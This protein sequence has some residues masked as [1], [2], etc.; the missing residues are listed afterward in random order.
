MAFKLKPI[1]DKARRQL[2]TLYL[3][4]KR[5]DVSG[6]VNACDA[7]R[8]GELIFAYIMD[9]LQVR[10]PVERLWISSMTREAIRNGLASLVPGAEMKNLEDASRSRSEADW[11]VGLN[12]TRAATIRARGHIPGVV[13]LG[14]VQTPTLAMIVKRDL[15]IA[16]FESQRFFVLKASFDLGYRGTWIDA[17]GSAR[18]AGLDAA[19]ALAEKVRGQ[20]GA[21]ANVERREKRERAPLLYD[22]TTLQRE[23]NRYYGLSAK[24]TLALAQSLYEKHKAIT[25]PRTDSRFLSSDMKPLLKKTA[26]TLLWHAPYREAVNYVCAL[27]TLPDRIIDD[28]KVSDHHAIIPTIAEHN[29]SAWSDHER[30]IFDL[31]A[32]RFLAVFHPPAVI[33]NTTVITEVVGE[34]FRSRGRRVLEPGWSAVYDGLREE[35]GGDEEDGDEAGDE[36]PADLAAGQAAKAVE[37]VVEERKTKPPAHFT[38]NTLLAAMETAGKLVED[39][40]L[41][42]A[43]KDSGLGTPATRA[44]II[45]TL[46]ARQYIARKGKRIQAT[47]KG[48]RVIAF[49]GDHPLCSPELTGAW[50]RRLTAIARGADSRASFMKDIVSFTDRTV[51]SLLEIESE[52]LGAPPVENVGPC[53]RCAKAGERRIVKETPRAYSCS[54]WKSREAPGCGFVI[55]K[56]IAGRSISADEARQLLAEGQV[57]PLEGF[58]KKGSGTPFRAWLRL[59]EREQGGEVGLVFEGRGRVSGTGV[60][61]ER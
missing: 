35:K 46:L 57:G 36:L 30:K 28:S 34:R 4:A 6:I 59:E 60:A 55:W 40:E 54:S 44:A 17:E 43:M 51:K 58:R 16:A 2:R 23:A 22:L 5:D 48:A 49:L 41:R 56:E 37:A 13:S 24:E 25:Y 1:D 31:I 38:E 10:K 61:V 39:D 27:D 21:V 15:E 47:E 20:V 26:K 14:R 53:P 29:F 8:E 52:E 19:E 18:I 42:E 3:L 11:L 9:L 12:A 33:E 32:R 45:E 50:E 7:G